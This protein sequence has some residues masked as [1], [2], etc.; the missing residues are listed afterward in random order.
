V[1]L[2]KERIEKEIVPPETATAGPRA[3]VPTPARP[4]PVPAGKTTHIERTKKKAATTAAPEPPPDVQPAIALE[5]APAGDDPAPDAPDGSEV[6]PVPEPP[7]SAGTSGGEEGTGVAEA[8]PLPEPDPSVVIAEI[9][10]RI[11]DHLFYPPVARLNGLEGKVIVRFGV[12][13]SGKPVGIEVMQSSGF[14]VLDEAAVTSVSR[15]AP[16]PVVDFVVKIP[17]VFDLK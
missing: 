10:E 16:L 11:R 15:S 5:T 14:D 12:D 13:S 6:G 8:P 17:V 1:S 2:V 3:P 4:R 7:A 9:K